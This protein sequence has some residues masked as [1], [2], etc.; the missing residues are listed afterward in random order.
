M[1]LLFIYSLLPK[2]WKYSVWCST[3]RT[4]LKKIQ[5][6]QRCAI[7]ELS[8]TKKKISHTGEHLKENNIL[9]IYQLNIFNNLFLLH[10]VKNRKVPNVFLSNFLRV[11]YHYP[12]SFPQ[13]NYIVPSF[14]LTKSKYTK[15]IHALKLYFEYRRKTYRKTCSF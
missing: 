12:T 2:L 8:F 14:K 13:N 7:L 5:S 10:R 3:N 4:Y 11:S 6:Q 15:T 1:S 9:N